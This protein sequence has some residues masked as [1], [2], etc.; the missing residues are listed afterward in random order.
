[1]PQINEHGAVARVDPIEE[2]RNVRGNFEKTFAGR[3]HRQMCSGHGVERRGMYS[4][5]LAQGDL[6]FIEHLL[7]RPCNGIDQAL[8]DPSDKIDDP[9]D[10]G[11]ARQAHRGLLARRGGS[12]RRHAGRQR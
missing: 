4:G 6:A 7:L 1:M 2:T 12:L 3:F 10:V 8:P 9:V 5:E 11:I